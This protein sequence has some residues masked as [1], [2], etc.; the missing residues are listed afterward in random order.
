[1]TSIQRSVLLS[2]LLALGFLAMGCGS[3]NRPVNGP[4]P[5]GAPAADT[6]RVFFLLP[7][8]FP[9][10]YTTVLHEDKPVCHLK[11][12]QYCVYDMPAGHAVFM[13]VSGNT[14]GLEG[15]FAGGKTYYIKAFITPG[16][17]STYVYWAQVEPQTEDWAKIKDWMDA[18]TFVELNPDKADPWE[19]KYANKNGDRLAKY[20]SGEA[21]PVTVNPASAE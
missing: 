2:A 8:G 1:M 7:Q 17:Q 15:D 20:K 21:K 4:A 13:S 11:N 16:F 14:E 18:G 12:R 3:M 5:N 19:A 6:A 10:G 9:G